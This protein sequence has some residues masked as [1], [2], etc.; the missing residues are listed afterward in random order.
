M[1]PKMIDDTLSVSPQ[2]ATEH[3]AAIA[4]AGLPVDHLQPAR[5]RGCRPA[6]VQPRSSGR[7]EA[8]RACRRVYHAGRLGQGAATSMPRSSARISPSCRS[9]CSPTAAPAR[10][11][12]RCGRC[13][14]AARGRPLPEILERDQ[15]RR[16]STWPAS[17]AASPMAAA[18]RPTSPTRRTRSSSSAAARPASRSRP[19]CSARKPD[20]DIAIIDPAD[21]HYYQPGW[22]HGRRRH[23]RPGDD[24]EDDGVADPAPACAGSRPPWRLSSPSKQRRHPRWL[25]RGEIHV[26]GRRPRASSSNWTAVEGLTET[27]GRN[28][29]TSNYRYDLA[30][31]TWELR[32][33]AEGRPRRLHPAADADQMRRRAAEGACTCPPTTGCAQAGSATSTSTSSMPAAVLFGVAD[34][35]PALMD[36]VERYHAQLHFQPQADPRR[37][38][39][40]YAP[41]SP[42]RCRWR[43]ARPSRPTFDMLHVVPPQIAPD[44]I[45]VS[46]AGRRGRL[47][48]CRPGDAAPQDACRTSTGLATPAT[49]RMPRRRPPRASRRRWWPH[50]LLKDLGAISGAD[51]VYDGYG[52][53]PLTVERG[54]IVLAEFGYG[55]K[56]LPSFPDP[57]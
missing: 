21:I 55:G 30:P 9:R 23:L 16:L 17:S 15:G 38:P 22:T 14:E 26:A 49:R 34:Y 56:R 24:G 43:D 35:V 6:R 44:F 42:N 46:P 3:V 5:R 33:G 19:A 37:W 28:G 31:Y 45:R 39:A 36:Y 12:R 1:Q 41:G 52:S 7:G 53:C 27:L 32:A 57:G 48:R 47:G 4:A 51:A 11:R 25:P 40:A 18:R 10:A 29:V 8:A 50:N 13:R 20:L 54:K 2:I